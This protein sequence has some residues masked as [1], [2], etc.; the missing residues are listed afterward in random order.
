MTKYFHH[1]SSEAHVEYVEINQKK[2]IGKQRQFF[3]NWKSTFRI[4]SIIV[5]QSLD[6]TM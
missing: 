2:V 4:I 6:F 5:I 1:A 3:F